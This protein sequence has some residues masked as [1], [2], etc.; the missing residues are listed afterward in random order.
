MKVTGFKAY[1][2]ASYVCYDNLC[3]PG[4]E[5]VPHSCRLLKANHS[6]PV[7][8]SYLDIYYKYEND[9]TRKDHDGHTHQNVKTKYRLDILINLIAKLVQSY[10]NY[11]NY[12]IGFQLQP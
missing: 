10:Y 1:L 4:Q 5:L 2:R 6:F 8:F 3:M 11:H 12:V 7:S 9:E